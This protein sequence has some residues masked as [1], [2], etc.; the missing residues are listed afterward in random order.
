MFS[1]LFFTNDIK[2]YL[3]MIY[4]VPGWF[5]TGTVHHNFGRFATALDGSPQHI[6]EDGSPQVKNNS[7]QLGKIEQY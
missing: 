7:P 6:A 3:L 5:A 4:S 2:C 1:S